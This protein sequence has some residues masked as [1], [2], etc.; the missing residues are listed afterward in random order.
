VCLCVCA[1][2]Q[3]AMRSSACAIENGV[4]CILVVPSECTCTCACV[5]ACVRVCMCMCVSRCNQVGSR[6]VLI[7]YLMFHLSVRIRVCMCVHVC[8]CM[9]VSRAIKW[10]RGWCSLYTCR[11]I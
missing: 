10:D 1:S 4:P 9:C 2:Q 6:M 3:A 5:C 7:V 8:M 11:S